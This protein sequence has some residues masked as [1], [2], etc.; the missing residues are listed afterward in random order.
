MKVG[1]AG[2]GPGDPLE[3]RGEQTNVLDE[4]NMAAHRNRVSMSTRHIRTG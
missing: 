2:E 3:R 1:N 4:G